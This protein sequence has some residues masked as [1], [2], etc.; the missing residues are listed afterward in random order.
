ML[1]HRQLLLNE[2]R[3]RACRAVLQ[4]RSTTRPELPRRV[5]LASTLLTYVGIHVLPSINT[6]S[7]RLVVNPAGPRIHRIATSTRGY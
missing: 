6:L 4:A 2:I 1:H 5:D 7:V 3:A